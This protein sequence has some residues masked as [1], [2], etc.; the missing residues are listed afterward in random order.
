MAVH[1]L[2][3][4]PQHRRRRRLFLSVTVATVMADCVTACW[5]ASYTLLFHTH[6]QI[7]SSQSQGLL[8]YCV[9]FVLQEIGVCVEAESAW[10]LYSDWRYQWLQLACVLHFFILP[11]WKIDLIYFIWSEYWTKVIGLAKR[12]GASICGLSV[13]WLT[14]TN[15]K[16]KNYSKY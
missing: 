14:K 6:M 2:I 16:I 1:C 12:R 8:G 11:V 5:D 9:S 15:R 10:C 13:L 3:Y 7:S 4:N